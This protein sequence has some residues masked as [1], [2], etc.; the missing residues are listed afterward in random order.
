MMHVVV[1]SSTYRSFTSFICLTKSETID[2]YNWILETA[3]FLSGGLHAKVIMTVI[4]LALMIA[5][6]VNFTESYNLLCSRHMR[7]NIEAKHRESF[8]NIERRL[9][10]VEKYLE[11]KGI[12]QTTSSEFKIAQAS[13]NRL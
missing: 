12:Q 3:K 11:K 2:N 6:S 4:E 5:V 13:L 9:G 8:A 1:M 10:Y 7:K